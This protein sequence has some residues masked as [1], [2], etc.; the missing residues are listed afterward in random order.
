MTPSFCWILRVL[1]FELIHQAAL[2]SLRG[3]M[4]GKVPRSVFTPFRQTYA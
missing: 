4:P 3:S 2:N 1:S